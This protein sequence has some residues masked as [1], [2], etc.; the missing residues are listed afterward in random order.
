MQFDDDGVP[1]PDPEFMKKWRQ[2]A[3]RDLPPT[4]EL[5]ENFADLI[6]AMCWA[7]E[8]DRIGAA[9]KELP[10]KLTST[11]YMLRALLVCFLEIPT[12]QNNLG[13]LMRLKAEI[14]DL[15][16]GRQSEL[17]V[18]VI[19][20][21][22]AP[23]KSTVH[24]FVQGMTART[25][26]ELVDSGEPVKQASERV[27]NALRK[28]RK[29]LRDVTGDTVRNWRAR[30]EE[31]PGASGAPDDAWQHYRAP[32]PPDFGS[33]SKMRGENLLKMLRNGFPALG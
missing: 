9:N 20:K 8:L 3:L 32:L 5:R 15:A 11:E 18:P 1:L 27:A 19:K 30:L 6:A 14:V 17:F 7:S 10:D 25:L 24:A 2:A 12:L 28:G 4:D 33:T 13:P 31:G 23:R 21:P 22:G 29:D 16:N 26:D